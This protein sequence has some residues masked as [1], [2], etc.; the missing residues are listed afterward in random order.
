MKG[1]KKI[2][3]K[4]LRLMSNV[5]AFF[6]SQEGEKDGQTI[7]SQTNENDW[8][9]RTMT[10]VITWAHFK[11]CYKP[12][13]TTYKFQAFLWVLELLGC[14]SIFLFFFFPFLY[15]FLFSRRKKTKER[16]LY[17]EFLPNEKYCLNLSQTQ[18]N[19]AYNSKVTNIS[20]WVYTQWTCKMKTR[21]TNPLTWK[22]VAFVT[23]TDFAGQ[24]KVS[25][26]YL[27]QFSS[28]TECHI[29]CGDVPL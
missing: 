24:I 29:L 23:D 12:I 4:S 28:Y 7:V 26:T 3:F 14:I 18:Q 10:L 9:H 22:H 6:A 19:S 5:N 15:F 1:M 27:K 13:R 25:K 8:L 16:G 2:W 20:V 17:F 11:V 21:W